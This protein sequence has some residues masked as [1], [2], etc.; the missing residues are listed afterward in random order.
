MGRED[1][2]VEAGLVD[3]HRVCSVDGERIVHRLVLVV[4]MITHLLHPR[5][6]VAHEG[7]RAQL[8]D[9]LVAAVMLLRETDRKRYSF[10]PE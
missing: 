2:G 1:E 5:G 7:Q 9:I 3:E 6:I 4:H 8:T 10:S